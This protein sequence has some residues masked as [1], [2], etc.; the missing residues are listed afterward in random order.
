MKND[1]TTP[2]YIDPQDRKIEQLK[3][4]ISKLKKNRD[5]YRGLFH[6]LLEMTWDA[7]YLI[8]TIPGT[9]EMFSRHKEGE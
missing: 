4:E 2:R 8:I 5:R 6:K 7:G 3:R 1:T 9:G